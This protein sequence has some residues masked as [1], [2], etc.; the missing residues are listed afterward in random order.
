MPCWRRQDFVIILI[1]HIDA[2]LPADF[3]A[4]RGSS[5]QGKHTDKP[6]RYTFEQVLRV[7]HK[8]T[9]RWDPK[10]EFSGK[11][12]PDSWFLMSDFSLVPFLC[13]PGLTALREDNHVQNMP[14]HREFLSASS[15]P[16]SPFCSK[17][18]ALAPDACVL[19]MQTESRCF[20][21]VP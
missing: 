8:F 13:L 20:K 11:S 9:D 16:T 6:S 1:L 10:G 3:L 21:D 4:R 19:E 5:S 7:Q 18:K 14:R 15:V 12:C 2:M 17:R